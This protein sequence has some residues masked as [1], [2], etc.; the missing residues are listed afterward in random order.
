MKYFVMWIMALSIIVLPSFAQYTHS[1]QKTTIRYIDEVTSNDTNFINQKIPA[2]TQRVSCDKG[3]IILIYDENIPDSIKTAFEIARQLWENKINNKQPIFIQ[4]VFRSMEKEVAIASDVIYWESPVGCPSAL[5]SQLT[6]KPSGSME[7][8]DGFVYF[9]SKLNWNCSFTDISSENYNLTT[10]ALRGIARCLGFGSS[11]CRKGIGTFKYY[12][13]WPTYFDKGLF[14][15]DSRLSDL[16]EGSMSMTSFVTSDDVYFKTSSSSYDIYAPKIYQEE[17]SLCYLK[18][19]GSLMSQ[20]LGIGNS[21]LSIDNST[22]DILNT[23]GWNMPMNGLE[24]KCDDISDDGIGSSFSEH[25]FFLAKNNES[26]EDYNWSFLL[27]N[28]SGNFEHVIDG[29]EAIFKIGKIENSSDYFININGDLE[30]KIECIYSVNGEKCEANPFYVSLELKPIII[31]VDNISKIQENLD[32]TLSLNV[33]YLGADFVTV[34]VEE[35]YNTTLRSYR[36][37]EPFIAHVSTGKISSMDYSWVTI[38]VTNRYGST[39]KTLE[40]EPANP[41][42]RSKKSEEVSGLPKLNSKDHRIQLLR[43]DGTVAYDGI[44]SLIDY[45]VLHGIFVKKEYL[46]DNNEILTNKVILP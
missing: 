46:D 4:M 28:K 17:H 21:W 16:Q 44:E 23:I 43:L 5:R 9:N 19:D 30:G 12:F 31:S 3:N 26:I 39:Y 10:M 36:F 33:N 18:Q 25:T 11:I 6:N 13:G 35:E 45:G 40:Y 22:L 38:I 8:P 24:I 32:F 2:K 37:D 27:K 14:S 1:L 15:H 29:K 20:N 7:S 42:Y 41:Y 34:E